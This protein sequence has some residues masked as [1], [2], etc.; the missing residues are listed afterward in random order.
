MSTRFYD[1][2][3]N[4]SVDVFEVPYLSCILAEDTDGVV[5]VFTVD[6][7]AIVYFVESMDHDEIESAVRILQMVNYGASFAVLV[8]SVSQFNRTAD[9][10]TKEAEQV[11]IEFWSLRGHGGTEY[12]ADLN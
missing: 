6:D 1:L 7:E 9:V 2:P 12:Q 4:H 10:L 11:D 8:C 3:S 5:C